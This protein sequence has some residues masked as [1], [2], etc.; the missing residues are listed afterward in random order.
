MKGYNKQ[1]CLSYL[2]SKMKQG[3]IKVRVTEVLRVVDDEVV[4]N[5]DATGDAFGGEG[6]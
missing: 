3:I 6:T 1:N 2:V 5:T 4:L